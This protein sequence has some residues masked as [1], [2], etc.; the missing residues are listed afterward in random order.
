M[1]NRWLHH[2]SGPSG[3][4]GR[5]TRD[6]EGLLFSWRAAYCPASFGWHGEASLIASDAIPLGWPTTETHASTRRYVRE[7]GL[8]G[9][10]HF[11][12][13]GSGPYPPRPAAPCQRAEPLSNSVEP[14][15]NA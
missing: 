10:F 6:W 9:H 5:P 13:S 2:P 4:P 1:A 12:T 8:L 3:P 7:S 15:A 11:R 14:Q